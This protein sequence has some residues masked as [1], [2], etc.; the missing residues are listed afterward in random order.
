MFDFNKIL[1]IVFIA[2]CLYLGFAFFLCE[3]NPLEWNIL[4]KILYCLG[5]YKILTELE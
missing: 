5:I 4:I 3:I 2:V 1:G